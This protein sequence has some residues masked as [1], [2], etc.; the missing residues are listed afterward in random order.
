MAVLLDWRGVKG[1]LVKEGLDSHEC[2]AVSGICY[3]DCFW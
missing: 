2:H 3:C 1:G